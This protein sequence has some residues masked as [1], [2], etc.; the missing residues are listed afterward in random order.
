MEV[1]VPVTGFVVEV[2]F[3]DAVCADVSSP[4]VV[5]VLLVLVADVMGIVVVLVVG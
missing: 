5:V 1:V 3:V 4:S 2:V